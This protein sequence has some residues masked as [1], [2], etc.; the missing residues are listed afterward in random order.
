MAETLR[1]FQLTLGRYLRDPQNVAPPAGLDLRRLRVYEELL[2]NNI[3]G[4]VNSCFPV[5]RKILGEPT[6]QQL[7]RQFFRDW[8]CRTPYFQE[9]PQEF[10]LFLNEQQGDDLAPWLNDLAHYEWVEMAVDTRDDTLVAYTD[11]PGALSVNTTVF[12]LQYNWPV[13][14]ISPKFLPSEPELTCLL[15]YR[16]AQKTVRFTQVSPATALIV[17]LLEEKPRRTDALIDA[18]AEQMGAEG[19][20][21]TQFAQSAI[22]ALVQDEIIFVPRRKTP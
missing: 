15:V 20:Q 7:V 1:K 4:F 18:L 9:I 11:D 17:S 12:N 10:L 16:D 19:E 6:W 8:R 14:R 22:D 3:S 2:F 5:C 21:F 13:H